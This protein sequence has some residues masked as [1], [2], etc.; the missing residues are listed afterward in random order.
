M[1][2][3]GWQ[4]A[5]G[6]R[7]LDEA[8]VA[9]FETG[10]R[11]MIDVRISPQDT[12]GKAAMAKA[13]GFELP[14]PPRTS[15]TKNQVTALWLSIDQ[16][17]LVAPYERGGALLV[18]LKDAAASGGA[19]VTDLS[20]ARAVIRLEGDGAREIIMKGGAADLLAADF[21]VGSVRRLNFAGI[22]AMVHYCSDR[23]DVLDLYVFRSFAD[24]AV[25]WLEAA[26]RPGAAISLFR[27]SPPPPT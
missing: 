18:P 24:Y 14:G 12:K 5:L 3:L 8:A 25:R 22:G 11:I 21:A 20:D 17:L 26:S 6:G 2:D 13:L 23:P 15:T 1:A 16:W 10:R 19:A 7:S 4:S 27:P 9:V